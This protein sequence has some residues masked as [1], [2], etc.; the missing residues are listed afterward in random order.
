MKQFDVKSALLGL[1]A[2]VLL[3]LTLGAQSLAPASQIGRFKMATM[4]NNAFV[5][6]TATGRVWRGYYHAGSGGN[7]DGEFLKAKT[8]AESSQGSE[9]TQDLPSETRL[10]APR[11]MAE[12][13]SVSWRFGLALAL[14]LATLFY[15]PE[16]AKWRSAARAAWQHFGILAVSL[17]CLVILAPVLLRGTSQQ[18]LWAAL[19]CLF[20][21]VVVVGALYE[22]AFAGR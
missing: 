10:G 8:G 14:E 4:D 20:P 16:L 22:G 11:P 17:A 18:K 12:R 21:L 19:L 3:V 1:A 9:A 13:P 15:L 2:G 5:I 7:T 6:D